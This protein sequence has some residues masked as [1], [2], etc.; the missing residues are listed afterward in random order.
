MSPPGYKRTPKRPKIKLF[1]GPGVTRGGGPQAPK[2]FWELSIKSID[3][4]N[5]YL[6]ISLLPH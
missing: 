4:P 2:F 5:K 1:G 6:S 3:P